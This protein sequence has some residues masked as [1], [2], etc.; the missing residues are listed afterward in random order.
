MTLRPTTAAQ[1]AH[2]LAMQLDVSDASPGPTEDRARRLAEIQ[3]RHKAAI[4]A[5]SDQEGMETP[6]PA[7]KRD[8]APIR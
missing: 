7:A 6:R 3:A 4:Q 1:Q 5:M 8:I 2:E